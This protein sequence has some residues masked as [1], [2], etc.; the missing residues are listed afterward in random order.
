M[1]RPS[2]S[3]IVDSDALIALVDRDDP[4]AETALSL[5]RKLQE[6][7]ALLLYPATAIVEAATTFQ[8]KLNKPELAAQIMASTETHHFLIEPI[9]QATI[10]AATQLFRPYGSKQNTPFDTI[11]AAVAQEHQAAIFSFDGWYRKVGLSL[12]SDVV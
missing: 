4:L 1:L 12:I 3:V 6:I 5:A 10:Q 8:R 2:Q 11:V 7:E 9:D